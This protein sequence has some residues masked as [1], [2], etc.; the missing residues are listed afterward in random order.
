M[1]VIRFMFI[2]LRKFM[3]KLMTYR[4]KFPKVKA[5]YS[6]SHKAGIYTIHN[7]LLLHK[8][9]IVLP[10]IKLKGRGGGGL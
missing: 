1:Y 8:Y 7:D 10:I 6:K 2:F 5:W 9:P 4:K 3:M